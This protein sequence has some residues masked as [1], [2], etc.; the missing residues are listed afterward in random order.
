M[1]SQARTSIAVVAIGGFVTMWVAFQFGAYDSQ[2]PFAWVPMGVYAAL[3]VTQGSRYWLALA[4]GAI[5]AAVIA[6]RTPFLILPGTLTAVLGPWLLARYVELRGLDRDLG[7]SAD[8]LRFG[9][10]TLLVSAI[11]PTIVLLLMLPTHAGVADLLRPWVNW[12]LCSTIGVALIVPM[13][14][15]LTRGAWRELSRQPTLAVTLLALSIAFVVAAEAVPVTVRRQWLA[16]AAIMITVISAIRL[17]TTLTAIIATIMTIGFGFAVLPRD[18]GMT[19]LA[20]AGNVWAFG[21]ALTA[22]TLT[23]HVLLAQRR[24]ARHRLR[25]AEFAHRMEVIDAAR[26]EQ[27]RLARDIH[28]AL[29]QELTAVSLLA[30]SL[31]RRLESLHPELA[32]DARTLA[33]TAA[34]AQHSA[35][36]IARGMAPRFEDGQDIGDALR[37]LTERVTRA[38]NVQTSV[39]LESVPPLHRQ[40]A[41]SLYRIA[42]EAISNALHHARATRIEIR[43][44]CDGE[45]CHLEIG[46]NGRGFDPDA[47]SA[48]H[49][50]GLRTMRYRCELAGGRLQ[51]ES[52]PAGGTYVRAELP[53]APRTAM[54]GTPTFGS[55]TVDDS[56]PATSIG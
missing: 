29:G 36:Q 54:V 28:D 31:Q 35:R 50:L 51:I 34:Q 48:G 42:Q 18:D 39:E 47:V 7:R 30:H 10:V 43:L 6:G 44:R 19:E 40:V 49:G 8:V 15:G 37:A 32:D 24:E 33:G 12:W 26:A 56:A 23:I 52:G 1:T 45:H 4:L 3:L 16:P 13:A 11:P 25:A 38:A 46:D 53:I 5:A 14:L 21:M 17:G 41:E 27:E 20:D 9:G 55:T 22:L 2:S